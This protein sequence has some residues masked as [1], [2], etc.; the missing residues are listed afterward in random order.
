MVRE[1]ALSPAQYETVHEKNHEMRYE[2]CY[3][4]SS[5]GVGAQRGSVLNY[6]EPKDYAEPKDYV[7]PKDYK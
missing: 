1:A 3:P 7:E 5:K 4:T 6:V 2:I